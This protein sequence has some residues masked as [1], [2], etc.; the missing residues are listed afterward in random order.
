MKYI[1]YA[2]FNEDF[3]ELAD[4][5]FKKMGKDV[6]IQIYDPENPSDLIDRGYK[7]ILARGEL[8]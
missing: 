2:A 4:G 6:G 8:P 5:I 3:I 1:C 7:V